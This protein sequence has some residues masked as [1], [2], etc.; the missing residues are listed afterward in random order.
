[1]L[2]KKVLQEAMS[3]HWETNRTDGLILRNL[4]FRSIYKLKNIS[5][6]PSLVPSPVY[7]F[8]VWPVQTEGM[9]CWSIS[10][11][12]QGKPHRSVVDDS[13]LI[14]SSLHTFPTTDPNIVM[15]AELN[16]SVLFIVILNFPVTDNETLKLRVQFVRTCLLRYCIY[17]WENYSIGLRTT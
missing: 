8:I 6:I 11:C 1:M 4:V 16:Y 5:P 2:W 13:T 17:C 10:I 7:V 9:L 14:S 12:L 3:R 15:L